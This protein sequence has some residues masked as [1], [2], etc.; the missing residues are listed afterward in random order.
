MDSDETNNFVVEFGYPNLS[1]I[2]L[3]ASPTDLFAFSRIRIFVD[4]VEQLFSDD[5]PRRFENWLP[6]GNR[7][8]ENG[9]QIT[10]SERP[11]V[12]RQFSYRVLTLG[13][14]RVLEQWT[15]FRFR[16]VTS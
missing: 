15:A 2:I 16:E 14:Q 4:Q 3:T 9:V 5:L 13:V 12:E 11:D 8:I 10:L 7:N 1:R 6:R